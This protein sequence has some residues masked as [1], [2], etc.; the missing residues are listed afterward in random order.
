MV[1]SDGVIDG[2]ANGAA[3]C[4]QSNSRCVKSLVVK[5]T[6]A[7]ADASEWKDT[8]LSKGCI[9]RNA[10][11]VGRDRHAHFVNVGDELSQH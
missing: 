11:W 2:R 1:D 9:K 10:E 3:S 4:S 6:K 7:E 5:M 8:V